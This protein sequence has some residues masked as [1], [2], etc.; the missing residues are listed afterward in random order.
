[1]IASAE[2]S[3]SAT[4]CARSR[5]KRSAALP[6]WAHATGQEGEVFQVP[7]EH[8]P[9]PGP[10]ERRQVLAA[11]P[12]CGPSR[13]STPPAHRRHTLKAGL[14]TSLRFAAAIPPYRTS[15]WVRTRLRCDCLIRMKEA[16]DVPSEKS[17]LYGNRSPNRLVRVIPRQLEVF[18][19]IIEDRSRT[20]VDE[21]RGQGPGITG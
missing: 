16:A 17:D 11:E 8:C 15:H 7:P 3:S 5:K 14:R 6:R 10:S 18:E 20:P 9:E 19:S 1:M 21:Q 4:R 13:T 2:R 12:S